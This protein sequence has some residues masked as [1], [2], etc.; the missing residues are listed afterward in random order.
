MVPYS[1]T[2]TS[3]SI[4]ISGSLLSP[5]PG[6]TVVGSQI[7][8]LHLFSLLLPPGVPLPLAPFLVLLELISYRFRALSLGI[9]LFANMM[10]GHSL[11]KISSGF[12]WT[13][14]SMRGILLLAHLALLS[15]VFASTGLESGVAIS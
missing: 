8:G 5:S 7:H 13:M 3:Y 12:A 14:L 15:I 11:V 9:C 4:I 2:V 10:A 6:T 1:F